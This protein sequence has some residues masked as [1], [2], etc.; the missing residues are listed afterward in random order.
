MRK[1]LPLI[2]LLLLAAVARLVTWRAVFSEG[3]V[4]PQ[5]PDA[6]FRLRQV[7]LIA[8]H[9][10]ETPPVDRY[11]LGVDLPTDPTVARN[12]PWL[13]PSMFYMAWALA[14]F[15]TAD[16]PIRDAAMVV[17]VV[18]GV[19]TTAL[20]YAVAL[21]IA[22]GFGAATAA[23][24]AALCMPVLWRT[25]LGALD[26]HMVECA[27]FLALLLVPAWNARLPHRTPARSV[28]VIVLGIAMAACALT[29]YWTV[30]GAAIL[31][32]AYSFG[33][34]CFARGDA[35][36]TA[37]L[38]RDTVS[39]GAGLLVASALNLAL[40]N[41]FAA[42][43]L[44]GLGAYALGQAA[45]WRAFPK[46]RLTVW[47][48][49]L[50]AA[51]LTVGLA[52]P[53][54]TRSV[55][56]S[57]RVALH[58]SAS[59]DV[60]ER[61]YETVDET[62]PLS[63]SGLPQRYSFL[64][65]AMPVALVLLARHAL[66]ERNMTKLA[67]CVLFLVLMVFS[68]AN[69]RFSHMAAAVMAP[70]VGWTFAALFAWWSRRMPALAAKRAVAFSIK[71]IVMAALVLGLGLYVQANAAYRRTHPAV[72]PGM[73][74]TFRWLREN[75]PPDEGLWNP[76]AEA[77]YRV[78]AMW[79]LGWWIL[80]KAERVPSA[81]GAGEGAMAQLEFFFK[82]DPAAAL[83]VA[84]RQNVRY[85]LASITQGKASSAFR[86]MQILPTDVLNAPLDPENERLILDTYRK[87]IHAAL[88]LFDGRIEAE[89]GATAALG[90]YRLL[91]ETEE[92]TETPF[93]PQPT[94]KVYEIVPAARLIGRA[95]P[96]AAVAASIELT[97][98]TGRTITYTDAATADAEGRF[99]LPL[100]YPS[101]IPSGET[102]PLGPWR[103]RVGETVHEVAVSEKA[104]LGGETVP[105]GE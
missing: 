69:R 67:V 77:P 2:L 70:V 62:A 54:L 75:T 46:A 17:P 82:A 65:L 11:S 15:D 7:R 56:A 96:G 86:I 84:R 102:Q 89:G 79:D 16:G 90:H 40:S 47:A 104:V 63:L 80:D 13:H 18:W 81:N 32:A 103:V 1:V 92:D 59:P 45:V 30:F 71:A 10:P 76:V 93:G 42:L 14:G 105:L 41:S 31:C 20:A 39:F 83:E 72:S 19:A 33:L 23:V 78:M 8:H 48:G 52:M 37:D 26:N 6:C 74:E 88:H 55:V 44:A 43:V 100:P 97:T 49:L 34:V 98:N 64:I 73:K 27:V 61:F 87:S 57:L 91:F 21:V 35:P 5:D 85:V 94:A 68:M 53:E 101:D 3:D 95:P 22:N 28:G 25:N 99:Q 12:E 36:K 24:F 60:T 38:Y 50:L 58:I 51:L 66:R 4:W 9:F 29:C